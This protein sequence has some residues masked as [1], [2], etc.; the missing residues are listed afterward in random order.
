L[1]ARYI[2][3]TSTA[4]LCCSGL[5]VVVQGQSPSR[6]SLEEAKTLARLASPELRGAEAAVEA[7]RGRE[8]QARALANPSFVYSTERTNGAGES[9]S[10]H[11]AG[12]EQQLEIGGQRGA[13]G[14]AASARR[15]AAEARL[16]GARVNLDF[17]VAKAYAQVIAA[18]RRAQLARQAGDAF[19]EA[20]RVSARRL[21]AGDISGYADRRL[22]LEAARYAALAAEATLV[23]RSARIALSALV[24]ANR[25]SSTAL[26]SI[27]TDTVQAALPRLTLGALT[28]SAFRNRVDHLAASLDA[29]ALSADAR[30]ASLERIPSPTLSVGYK[31]EKSPG[32]SESLTGFAAGVSFPVPLFDR[33]RGAIQAAEAETRRAQAGIESARR[34]IAR[35]VADAHEALVAVEQ[36]RSLLAPQLGT[37]AAAALRS[38]QIAYLEGEITL[39]EWLD[40]VRAYHEAES[41]YS[42]LL[43]EALVRR[44]T[45][46]RAVA[47]PLTDLTSS[48]EGD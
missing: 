34:R 31:T 6:L 25:D 43:G 23:S 36:Q 9:N 14:R 21:A 29:E 35:E 42:T 40:A 4:A 46:E 22:R 39:L 11:I 13:R 41:A 3:I 16:A 7:S 12:I 38:A 5:R 2:L 30:L 18:D 24:S 28:A 27:L 20:G 10:Q 47:S 8:V 33:R 15:Q 17:E 32:T 48:P 26:S 19:T 1:K 44:A 45:L 37:P